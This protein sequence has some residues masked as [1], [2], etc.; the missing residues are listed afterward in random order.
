MVGSVVVFAGVMIDVVFRSVVR[1]R[2]RLRMRA[3]GYGPSCTGRGRVRRG[4]SHCWRQYEN[5]NGQQTVHVNSPKMK[6]PCRENLI[7]ARTS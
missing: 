6:F 1:S 3:I 5:N 7:T 2:F 4:Q